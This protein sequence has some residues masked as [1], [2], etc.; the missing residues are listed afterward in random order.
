MDN[1]LNQF[2]KTHFKNLALKPPLFY[3]WENGIRFEISMPGIEHEDPGNLNQIKERTKTLFHHVFHESDELLLITD[4]HCQASN[5][6]LQKRPTKV[7]QKYIKSKDRVRKLQHNVLPYVFQEE[8]EG[9]DNE[10]SVTHRFSLR[11]KKNDIRYTQ[12]LSA[13]SYEDFAHPTT[14]LKGNRESGVDIYF[15]NLTRKMMFHLY[16]DRGCDIIAAHKEEL[17]ELYRNC[18][19]WILDYDREKVDQLFK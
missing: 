15:I 5:Q 3:S 16:D 19:D 9:E 2:L 1:I 13:I 12:L 7:Y 8:Y 18:N 11:C 6:F 4:V 10:K 14:I 17:V